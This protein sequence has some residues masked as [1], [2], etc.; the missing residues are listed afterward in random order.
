MSRHSYTL[1]KYQVDFNQLTLI[2]HLM[3]L[4]IY[5]QISSEADLVLDSRVHESILLHD[6]D[7]VEGVAGNDSGASEGNFGQA[8]ISSALSGEQ[9]ALSLGRLKEFYLDSSE[10]ATTG[11]SATGQTGGVTGTPSSGQAVG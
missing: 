9:Q 5:F 11:A 10:P 6:G 2:M 8:Q 4:N 7:T 1:L 3:N